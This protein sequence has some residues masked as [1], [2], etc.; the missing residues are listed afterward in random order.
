MIMPVIVHYIDDPGSQMLTYALLDNQSD[1][2]F[3]GEGLLKKLKAPTDVTLEL[4]TVLAK[5]VLESQ[6]I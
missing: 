1:A 5:Q 3:I 4:T 6:V 2:C